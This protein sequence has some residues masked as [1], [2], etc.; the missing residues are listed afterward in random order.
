[1]IRVFISYSHS[2]DGENALLLYDYLK[3]NGKIKPILAP[4]DKETAIENAEKIAKEIDSCNYFITFYTT[5]GK[6]NE[7]V[8]QELGYAFNHARQN[9]IKIIPI[10]SKINEEFKGFLTSKSY[11]FYEGFQ[12]IEGQFVKT[13]E[14]I[15]NHLIEEYKHPIKLDFNIKSH[16]CVYER[17]K[18]TTFDAII[19]IHNNS[20]KKMQDA[21]LDFV[22]TE[23]NEYNSEY[24]SFKT[25]SAF[26][27]TQ[28]ES[29]VL[30]DFHKIRINNTNINRNNLLLRYNFLLQDIL[31][32]N[33]YEIPLNIQI[34]N[35]QNLHFFVYLNIPLFGTTYYRGVLQCQD[36]SWNSKFDCCDDQAN[37]L[38]L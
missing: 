16:S 25:D 26:I 19:L 36:R 17:S 4:K 21:S 27:K 6:K 22:F 18:S 34:P 23:Y 37:S 13:M 14:Q 15:N 10:F 1:M 31:G 11:N 33:V 20:P 7:W 2:S 5:E 28:Y 29:T 12:L 3:K 32:L 8:N 9:G 38:S 35:G 24:F 30:P